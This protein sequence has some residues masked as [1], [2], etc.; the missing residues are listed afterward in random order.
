MCQGYHIKILS[1]YNLF[2][3]LL[4]DFFWV[5][6]FLKTSRKDIV[7]G[8]RRFPIKTLGWKRDIEAKKKKKKLY[9]CLSCG[10]KQ[11]PKRYFFPFFCSLVFILFLTWL[12]SHWRRPS[13]SD[14]TEAELSASPAANAE[15]KTKL[16]LASTNNNGRRMWGNIL[17]SWGF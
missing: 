1:L 12:C 16:S 15:G 4:V 11:I 9:A 8:W 7:W 14:I 5:E 3:F 17:L 2:I 10:S 6:W 13:D